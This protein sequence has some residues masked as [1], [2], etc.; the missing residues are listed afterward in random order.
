MR[1]WLALAALAAALL[2]PAVAFADDGMDMSPSPSPSP[3]AAAA[4][5]P[6]PAAEEAPVPGGQL[7][8]ANCAGCH[9]QEGEGQGEFPSLKAAAFADIVAEKVR[10]GGGAMPAFGGSLPERI[11]AVSEYVAADIADPA[12]REATVSEGGDHYRLYCAGCHGA[13]GRGGV[14][15]DGN[16]PSFEGMP[17]ANSLSAMLQGPGQMPSFADALDTR[18]QAAVSRYVQVL[19]TPPSPGGDGLGYVGPVAEGLVAFAALLVIMLVAGWLSFGT[20]GT[21]DE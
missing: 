7:Y 21:R 6:Q 4:G 12:A 18:A 1:R 8:T 14:L 2:V 11:E 17:A 20:G 19:V 16:A 10:V 3:S 9:G 5:S 15:T 13:T